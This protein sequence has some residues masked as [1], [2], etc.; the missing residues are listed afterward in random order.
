[1][2]DD[3]SRA[4][5]MAKTYI[6]DYERA[7]LGYYHTP[8]YATVAVIVMAERGRTVSGRE[9]RRMRRLIRKC[10][11]VTA[12]WADNCPA[13]YAPMLALID[14]EIAA[15]AGNIDEAVRSYD[16]ARTLAV[17]N[18]MLWVSG[19]ASHRLAIVARRHGYSLFVE[20]ALRAARDTYE[21]WGAA[22]LVRHLDAEL[23]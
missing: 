22:A 21:R 17:A 6:H 4:W 18:R 10:R 19:L 20:A 1:M 12:R 14:A 23:A 9:R 2:F 7:L 5:D 8:L 16:R 11:K 13:N 3:Y 15:F